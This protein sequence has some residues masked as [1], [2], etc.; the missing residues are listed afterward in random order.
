[1]SR[2]VHGE[3]R[4][5]Q[6]HPRP[7]VS[8]LCSSA[9]LHTSHEPYPIVASLSWPGHCVPRMAIATCAHKGHDKGQD[10]AKNNKN[11][12]RLIA[13]KMPLSANERNCL[14]LVTRRLPWESL[15]KL[16]LPKC[17]SSMRSLGHSYPTVTGTNKTKPHNILNILCQSCRNIAQDHI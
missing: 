2:T 6:N 11:K 9:Y 3:G 15:V 7:I 14:L 1:V 17:R 10:Q 5:N 12:S 16:G 13:E 4:T 8:S